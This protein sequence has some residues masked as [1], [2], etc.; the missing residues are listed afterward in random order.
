MF[1]NADFDGKTSA[2]DKKKTFKIREKI[3]KK[4]DIRTNRTALF[5]WQTGFIHPA[6]EASP[7]ANEVS[8]FGP[9]IFTKLVTIYYCLFVLVLSCPTRQNNTI[10][11]SIYCL[12]F[13]DIGY[14][15]K[16]ALPQ[17]V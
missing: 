8:P 1:F 14:F 3:I 16:V 2:A 17:I 11:M 15:A 13:Q 6:D 12:F 9:Y 10:M 4:K 7:L 5:R